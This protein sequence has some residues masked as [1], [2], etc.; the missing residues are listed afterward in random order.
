M[1]WSWRRK[2]DPA[3]ERLA[4]QV[5]SLADTVRN[6]VPALDGSGSGVSNATLSSLSS[7]EELSDSFRGS[8]LLHAINPDSALRSTAVYACV[9]LIAG[10]IAALPLRIY[11]RVSFEERRVATDHPVLPLIAREPNATLS[12]MVFWEAVVWHLLLRGNA[13]ALIRRKR[14]GRAIGLELLG[15]GCAQPEWKRLDGLP[16]LIYHVTTDEGTRTYDQ[17]DVL[18][19]PCF[20]W[21]GTRAFTPISYAGQNAIG[22]SLAADEHS[23]AFFG[24]GARTDIAITFPKKVDKNQAEAIRDYWVRA[25]GG[26]DASAWRRPAVLGDDAKI[27]QL[28]MTSE[29]AQLLE[30]RKYQIV[31]IARIFGVPPHLIAETEKSTSWGSGIEEQNR[32]F[33]VYTLMPH[34]ERIEQE[35]D[36]K[37]V[38]SPE[39]YAEFDLSGLL[40][41]DSK[42]RA[43]I[44]KAAIGGTQNPGWMTRNEIRRAEN[45]A[46]MEG[47]DVLF[48]PSAKAAANSESK[49][50]TA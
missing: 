42:S 8:R 36:R 1:A 23:A 35:L 33:L 16:R 44:Y 19:F 39:H 47:G 6:A 50:E 30:A 3:L 12:A 25:H 21:N 34:I 9:R 17:D 31:D 5:R 4:D 29:D 18:H 26:P 48:T 28:S 7:W 27:Q 14:N 24:N 15:A 49:Q 11:E 20:G 22:I 41:A 32:G 38:R 2:P 13:Y 40:R 37:L 46:P 43:E 10:T 45:L